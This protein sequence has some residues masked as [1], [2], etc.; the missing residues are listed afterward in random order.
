M[1][2]NLLAVYQREI[3]IKNLVFLL[4]IGQIDL[5]PFLSLC[6]SHRLISQL[7]YCILIEYVITNQKETS[8]SKCRRSDT[9]QSSAEGPIPFNILLLC[10]YSI[11]LYICIITLNFSTLFMVSFIAI[12]TLNCYTIPFV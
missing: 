11:Y 9:L 5:V 12:I 2:K 4:V 6:H 1:A 3:C 8:S 7:G 10:L